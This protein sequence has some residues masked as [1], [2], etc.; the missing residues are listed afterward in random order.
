MSHICHQE[1]RIAKMEAEMSGQ[2]RDIQNLIKRLDG[3]T[4][5][6]WALVLVLIPT[7][8]SLFGFLIWQIISK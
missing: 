2:N 5:G 8:I 3:L 7:T 4:R 6:L 1:S